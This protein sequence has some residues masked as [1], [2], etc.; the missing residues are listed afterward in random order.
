MKYSL[1]TLGFGATKLSKICQK[2]WIFD[3]SEIENFAAEKR[4]FSR[5]ENYK[6]SIA[7]IFDVGGNRRF[8]EQQNP[9]DFAC[10]GTEFRMLRF[11]DID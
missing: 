4:S 6:F 11:V 2:S 8:P 3:A 9:M 5:V 10:I 1:K 7:S